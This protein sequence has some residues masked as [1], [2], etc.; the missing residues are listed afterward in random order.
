MKEKIKKIPFI[1]KTILKFK[2]LFLFNYDRRIFVNNFINGANTNDTIDYDLLIEIHK[3]EKGM[4][5]KEI[6][7]FGKEKVSKIIRL[8]KKYDVSNDKNFSYN[9]ALSILKEYLLIYEKNN[10]NEREEYKMVKLFLDNYTYEKVSCGSQE[11]S[12]KKIKEYSNIDYKSFLKSRHSV[13][14]YS[15]KKLL[16][17]DIDLAVEMAIL[18]PSAC[19]RQMCKIYYITKKKDIIEKYVK[20]LSLFELKNANY[21]LITFDINAFYY[22]DERNQGW[23]NSGLFCMNFV[24]ALHSLGIGSCIAQFAN[25]PKEEELI[26]KEL[27][28]K[29]SERIAGVVV[30]GYYD[31]V[32][33]IPYSTRKSKDDIFKII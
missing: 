16:Q 6:R 29:K 24:N 26:K 22:L 4:S 1:G 32:S 3:L 14:N 11:I 18:S 2:S 7:P 20:G 17:S 13:R 23:F 5:S 28:I 12:Y 19:N 25:S 15:E 21:F 9:L 30:C 10:W 31:D 8:L 27:N 33:K